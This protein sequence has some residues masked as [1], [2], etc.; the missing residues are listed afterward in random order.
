M[1]DIKEKILN[2]GFNKINVQTT[3]L[4][5]NDLQPV[6]Y[7]SS[8]WEESRQASPCTVAHLHTSRKTEDI[9]PYL[10]ISALGI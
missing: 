7:I 1:L 8:L 3:Y 9:S 4:R 2:S 10:K 5:Y 6:G